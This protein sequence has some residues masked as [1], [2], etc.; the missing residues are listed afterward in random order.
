MTFTCNGW[1]RSDTLPWLTPFDGEASG[2][3]ARSTP[4]RRTRTGSWRPDVLVTPLRAGRLR[5]ARDHRPLGAHGRA[6]DGRLLVIPSAELNCLAAG[7]RG[8][9][10]RARARDRRS[11]RAA[12]SATRAD[13]AGGRRLDHASTAASRTSRTPTG[14]GSAPAVGAAATAS[15]GIEVFNAGCELEIGRGALDRPLGRAARARPAVLRARDRRL[16]PPGL[17]CGL[18]WTWVRARRD[19]AGGGARRAARPGASTARPG[20]DDRRA[21]RST[22]RAVEV[23]CSPA[24]SVTLVSGARRGARANAGRLG[25]PNA[26]EIL[27]ATPTG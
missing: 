12:R 7:R 2:C 9:R 14:P 23:R 5:R 22:A 8:R 1:H 4:T 21:S 18:A 19:D 17:D 10:P 24:A 20:R 6:V 15:L 3:A 27:D 11:T 16:A 25:Y 13:L 26:A